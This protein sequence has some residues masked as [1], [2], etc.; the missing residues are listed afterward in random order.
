MP[1]RYWKAVRGAG[2]R[3][4]Q[5]DTGRAGC[6]RGDDGGRGTG[7][8]GR[9]EPEGAAGGGYSV[10]KLTDEDLRFVLLTGDE[11]LAGE[12]VQRLQAAGSY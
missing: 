4:R 1:R 10:F 11:V 8:A 5:A 9:E 2:G 7:V 12:R 3:V 6:G